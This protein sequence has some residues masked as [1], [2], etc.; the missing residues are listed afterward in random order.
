MTRIKDVGI[1]KD[2]LLVT[3]NLRVI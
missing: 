1:M 2:Y 3:L